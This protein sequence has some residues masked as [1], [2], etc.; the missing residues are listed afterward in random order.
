M[1]TTGSGPL[2][3]VSMRVSCG[4]RAQ[5]YLICLLACNSVGCL[6]AEA[7]WAQ[8]ELSFNRSDISLG[9]FIG[10]RQS[11]AGDF[12][13]D[14]QA[15]LVVGTPTTAVSPAQMLILLG[16][17]DGNFQA[18]PSVF[19]AQEPGSI[20]VRDFNNDGRQD[21]AATSFP[22][23]LVAIRLGNGDGTFQA[24][25]MISTGNPPMSIAASDFDGDGTQD[26]AISIFLN[27]QN[28]ARIYLGNGDGTFSQG[29]EIVEGTP[30]AIAVGDFNGDGQQDLAAIDF[31]FEDNG[32][33]ILLGQGDGTFQPV[34]ERSAVGPE[35]MSLT[36]GDFDGNG[37]QDVATADPN[38]DVVS[39]LLGNGDGT[40][41]AAQNVSPGVQPGPGAL[42]Q[43][44]A[45]EV[46]DFNG[47][48]HDDLVTGNTRPSDPP[49]ES[50]ISV[51]LG[52]GDGTFEPAREFATATGTVSL[53]VADFNNDD[54][55]DVATSNHDSS[56]LTILINDSAAE[57]IV[58]IDI[59]PGRAN[60]IDPTSNGR[61]RVAILASDGFDATE[62]DPAT[63]RFGRTGSEA[64]PI[65]FALKDVDGDGNTDLV[66]RFRIQQTGI[67]C[68]DTS[69]SLTAR[70]FDGQPIMG[71]DSIHT[72]G[73]GMH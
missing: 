56:T 65:R 68:G 42:V 9:T 40:F 23:N 29:Q 28:N 57:T 62:V 37:Q 27:G 30:R 10:P 12:N 7:S 6:F 50:G 38:N 2:S 13:D 64:A 53:V 43:P 61:I 48:G 45:I 4:T 47:D 66:L 72:V 20:L 55:P 69:A 59:R 17:G 46:A 49:V 15:D 39:V 31:I 41:A 22:E 63:V 14:G 8:G 3:T 67:A 18:A 44:R 24:P 34:P 1:S 26:L 73:C 21:L 36:V 71:S 70:T 52:R 58:Q 60:R 54:R 25:L 51:L 19:V 16:T 32:V 5:A 33:L 11:A 35:A